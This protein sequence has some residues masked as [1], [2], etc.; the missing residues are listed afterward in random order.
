M[1][2]AKETHALSQLFQEYREKEKMRRRG[3]AKGEEAG[4]EKGGG[5]GEGKK[6]EA[7]KKGQL[8]SKEEKQTWRKKKCSSKRDKDGAVVSLGLLWIKDCEAS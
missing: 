7:N 1:P 8:T 3:E 4:V 6:R 2:Q 5:G